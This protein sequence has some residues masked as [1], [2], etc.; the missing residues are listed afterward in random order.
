MNQAVLVSIVVSIPACHSVDRGSIPRRG[1]I[2]FI[3]FVNA[4]IK[5]M[6][7]HALIFV[8]DGTVLLILPFRCDTALLSSSVIGLELL[9]L[10]NKFADVL[11]C[12]RLFY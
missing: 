6:S 7:R 10:C 2:F 12:F 4:V 11:H 3:G 8:S 9:D 1:G 5:T